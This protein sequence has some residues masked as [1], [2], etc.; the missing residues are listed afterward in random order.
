VIVWPIDHTPL[1]LD[2]LNERVDPNR[3]PGAA[4]VDPQR[5]PV[6]PEDEPG[7]QSP[8]RSV[9]GDEASVSRRRVIGCGHEADVR[10]GRGCP[11]RSTEREAEIDGSGV[12]RPVADG[13]PL[14]Q[15]QWPGGVPLLNPAVPVGDAVGRRV[16]DGT[17]GADA[18]EPE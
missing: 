7:G 5:D 8:A 3:V 4:A 11:Q 18:G 15:A 10:A 16:P 12:V 9:D 2:L 14:L 17:P 13:E 6:T 1:E